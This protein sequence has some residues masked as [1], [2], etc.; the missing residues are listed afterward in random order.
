[1]KFQILVA[2]RRDIHWI[3]PKATGFPPKPGSSPPP[4]L[5]VP[6]S[7]PPRASIDEP[8]SLIIGSFQSTPHW[9]HFETRESTPHFRPVD[10]ATKEK[11]L[12]SISAESLGLH[13]QILGFFLSLQLR[14]IYHTD[15]KSSFGFNVLRLLYEMLECW[16]DLCTCDYQLFV[17][18]GLFFLCLSVSVSLSLSLCLCLSVSLSLFLSL[19][20]SV[21][22]SISISLSL[23]HS[24]TLS[25]S[26][27]RYAS[28]SVC[29]FIK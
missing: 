7:W 28:L 15:P 20:L 8:S 1:M 18:K 9:I 4:P 14:S 24:L 6:T 19:C 2:T 21:S 3:L 10:S 22:L 29:L 27:F 16:K 26:L 17:C 25:F 5:L 13:Y 23:S 11:S 12:F